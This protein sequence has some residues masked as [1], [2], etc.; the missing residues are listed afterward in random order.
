MPSAFTHIFVGQ[1]LGRTIKQEKMPARFW[2]LAAVCSVLPDVDILGF[3]MGVKY[4][5]VFGHRG[6][7][8]SIPFALLVG[9]I[10]VLAAFPSVA[11]FSRKWWGLLGFFAFVIVSHGL[12]DSVTDK[13]LGVGFFIPLDDTRYH[14]PWRPVHASP[15][16]ILRF[17]SQSGLKVLYN[18]M[19]WIWIPVIALYAVAVI[20]RRKNNRRTAAQ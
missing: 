20:Y 16:N 8:H 3:Y 4:G 5:S 9:L 14:M 7:F 17:F 10:V 11:R 15:M 2:V 13:G 19:L 12:L 1:A 18:E 6:F